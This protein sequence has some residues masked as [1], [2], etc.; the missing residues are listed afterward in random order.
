MVLVGGISV[1]VNMYNENCQWK[2]REVDDICGISGVNMY[3]ENCQW[4]NLLRISQC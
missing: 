1:H 3:T 4:T 2:Y